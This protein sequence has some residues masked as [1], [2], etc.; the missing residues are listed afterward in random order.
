[1]KSV[2][3]IVKELKRKGIR[4]Q[5]VNMKESVRKQLKSLSS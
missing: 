2:D 3:A 1:M 4:V 5:K